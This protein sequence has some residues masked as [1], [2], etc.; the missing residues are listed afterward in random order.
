MY[1]YIYMNYVQVIMKLC[2]KIKHNFFQAA[3]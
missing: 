2:D 1:M 3:D